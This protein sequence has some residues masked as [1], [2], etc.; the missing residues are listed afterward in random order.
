MNLPSFANAIDFIQ[1]EINLLLY[2]LLEFGLSATTIFSNSLLSK[3]LPLISAFIALEVILTLEREL[4][5]SCSQSDLLVLKA[6]VISPIK[7]FGFS[8]DSSL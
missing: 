3:P 4:T 6:V 1:D 8:M 5:S 7:I 2:L